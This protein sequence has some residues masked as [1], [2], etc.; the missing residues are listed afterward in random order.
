M[1]MPWA[2][3]LANDLEQSRTHLILQSLSLYDLTFMPHLIAL[4]TVLTKVGFVEVLGT[5]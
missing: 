2:E 5:V 3:R 1:P 4:V